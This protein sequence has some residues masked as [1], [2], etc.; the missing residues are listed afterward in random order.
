VFTTPAPLKSREIL[1][2]P[3]DAYQLR[4]PG[5]LA[6]C[7]GPT[8]EAC[9]RFVD[10]FRGLG[11]AAEVLHAKSTDRAEVLA[12]WRRRETLV[13]C[14]VG[15]V[16]EGFDLPSIECVIL[17]RS[18]GTCG[19]YLQ[20]TGRGL[21]PAPGKT[22]CTLLDLSGAAHLHGSPTCDRVYSLE[23]KGIGRA[24]VAMPATTL[25]SVCGTAPPC[26]CGEREQTEMS[27]TGKA[28]DLRP[29]VIAMRAESDDRRIERLA[30]WIKQGSEKG[31]RDGWALN[32]FRGV[33]AGAPSAQI[34][35]AAR[36]KAR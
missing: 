24:G 15:I 11:V 10:E 31:Y 3:V 21:R 27:I 17:A 8:V 7:F 35:E 36:A 29:W 23:G 22:R 5:Q 4:T 18:V 2:R 25:C 9:N 32:K 33:Y 16:S 12:R 6:V 30:R 20:T 26:E 28:S 14:N 19:F 13:V 34:V 1:A